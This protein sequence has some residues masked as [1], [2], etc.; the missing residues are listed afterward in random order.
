[1]DEEGEEYD[2]EFDAAVEGEVEVWCPYCGERATVAVDPGGGGEQDYVEDCPVCC[3]PWSV[4]VHITGSGE[5]HVSVE[6][7]Q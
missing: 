5:V 3:R 1:M 2:P 6:E 7:A 4:H